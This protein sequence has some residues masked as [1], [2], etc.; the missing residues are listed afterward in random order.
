LL[1]HAVLLGLINRFQARE[2]QAEAEDREIDSVSRVLTR[3]GL[4]TSWQLERVKKGDNSGFFYGGCKVLFHLAEGTFARVYRGMKSESGEPFAVKVLR[5]RFSNDPEAVARF[6][7]EAQEGMKLRHPNIVQ[8]VDFGN[9]ERQHYMLMEYVEG[10]N[11]RDLL[12]IRQRID[13][14]VAL[15]MMLGLSRGLKYALEQGVTHRDIKGSNILVSTNGVAKLVDFGLATIESEGKKAA[16]VNP[17][18]VDYSALER[19]CGSEKGD[20][21]SDIFFLGCVYYQM[22]TGQLAMTETE[23]KDMLAKMLKRS[24]GAIKPLSELRHAPDP[25]L[26]RIIE[27]MMKVEL[28]ARYQIIDEVIADLEAYEQRMKSGAETAVADE[29]GLDN[30]SIFVNTLRNEPKPESTVSVI[31]TAPLAQPKNGA[32]AAAEA[33]PPPKNVLCVESQEVVQDAFKKSLSRM[34]YR[35]LLV[36]DPERAAERCREQPPDALI[37]DADGLG[38]EAVDTFVAIHEQ[39]HEEGHNLAALVLLSPRQLSLKEKLPS[40]DRLVVLAKPIKMKQIQDAM[41]QLLPVS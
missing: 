10:S 31:A 26:C 1:D 16:S 33:G 14:A 28:K 6:N 41:T 17:R 3:K 22:L 15:P 39:A 27:K 19:T 30:E 20:P 37:F 13:T 25:E 18:T 23:T 7:K 34:G 5:K 24:F 36:G 9:V 12:K 35:V 32:G 8:I 40:G 38:P 2:V 21:R 4:L 29:L 11:L